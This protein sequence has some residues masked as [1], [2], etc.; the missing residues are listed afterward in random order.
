MSAVRIMVEGDVVA[1]ADLVNYDSGTTAFKAEPWIVITNI[2]PVDAPLQLV[3]TRYDIYV[4]ATGVR[5]VGC[6]A[7]TLANPLRFR[8]RDVVDDNGNS[9][10]G[11]DWMV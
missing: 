5:F 2:R 11:D 6:V 9:F 7:A 1:L 10:L 3:G 8:A 4:E